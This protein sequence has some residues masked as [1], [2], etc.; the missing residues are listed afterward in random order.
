MNFPS[1]L[2]YPAL[3]YVI[4]NEEE[5]KTLLLAMRKACGWDSW[6]VSRVAHSSVNFHLNPRTKIGG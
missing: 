5:H 4:P 3:D 2:T 1:P 6:S